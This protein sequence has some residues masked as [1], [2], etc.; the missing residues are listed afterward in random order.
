MDTDS[1]ASK[2]SSSRHLHSLGDNMPIDD[3]YLS[4][5]MTLAIKIILPTKEKIGIR[6]KV[7]NHPTQ[8][9]NTKPNNK[10]ERW[11]DYV[12]PLI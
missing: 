4:I 5:P 1:V 9:P 7:S 12:P 2:S 11:T 6:Y 3:N 8:T 10:K